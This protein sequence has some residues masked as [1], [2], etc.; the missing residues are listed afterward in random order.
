LPT[1][2]IPDNLLFPMSP[3]S[4]LLVLAVLVLTGTSGVERV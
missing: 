3:L 4:L 2:A 1:H